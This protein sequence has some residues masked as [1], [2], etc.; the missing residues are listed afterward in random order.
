MLDTLTAT[1]LAVICD[2][3]WHNMPEI[4][5]SGTQIDSR[6]MKSGDLFFAL[7][8]AQTDGHHFLSK[9][10]DR[11]HAAVVSKP[12][13]Q[14]NL[15]QLLVTSPLTALQNLAR[16]IASETTAFKVAITGS[17]GKTGTKEML[18]H[19]LFALRKTHATKGNFNNDI[20]A[21]L[22]ITRMPSDTELLICELG[23]NH[24]GEIKFLSEMLQPQIGI[25]TKIATSHAGHFADITDIAR[26][27]AEIFEGMHPDSLALL[28]ADDAQLPLLISAAKTAGI[29]RIMTFGTA[30]HADLKLAAQTIGQT[31]QTIT[32]DICGTEIRFTVGMAAPHWA[33]SAL[34][35]LGVAYE[36]GLPLKAVA[37]ALETMQDLPGRGAQFIAKIDNHHVIV[38]DD[39]YN[40]GPASMQ[41][42][43]ERLIHAD[44]R[45]AAILSD[46][47]EL[48]D[49]T[50]NAHLELIEYI[51]ASG[52]SELLL[53]GPFMA[54]LAP[55]LPSTIRC[56]SIPNAEE[57]KAETK[58]LAARSD[59]V[60][61]K[62]SHGSG[63]HHLA[64]YLQ[65]FSS[66]VT[67]AGGHDVT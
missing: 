47:L 31:H 3:T 27:K 48:G 16:F 33:L 8:G 1:Q 35:C 7:A 43:L 9:L 19:C 5:F 20:G 34:I 42:A 57:A 13:T 52:I 24:A 30:A 15:P 26:A 32:A 44:G 21:P 49:L 55:K 61:I 2:G 65:E 18:A 40:A 22:T 64:A 17:V 60:L 41:S 6:R 62:G 59:M 56:I 58:A 67:V 63:A 51:V 38:I 54:T 66:H 36:L 37:N 39:A 4:H 23:M 28:P 25:I 53:I 10:D 29:S 12:A 46:M 11:C 14:S 45:K 50:A